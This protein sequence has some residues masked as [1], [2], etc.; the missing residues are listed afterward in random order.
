MSTAQQRDLISVDDYLAG[1]LVSKTKHEYLGGYVYAMAG[2]KVAQNVI[3][4]NIVSGL[5]ERLRGR[6][7]RPYN[8]DMKIRI[9]LPTQPRFYYPDASVVCRSNPPDYSYQDEPILL[10]EVLSEDTRRTDEGEKKD[11]YLTISSLAVYM[12][13]EQEA[14]T[15]TVYRR[16]EQGFQREVYQGPEAV[17]ALPELATK[18]PLAEIYEDVEFA[19]ETE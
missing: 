14:A 11:A 8:S 9:R 6:K 3:A 15:V 4:V 17:I 12:L 1:E 5:R 2:A 10:V 18:L 16:T 19:P 7:C 13:V